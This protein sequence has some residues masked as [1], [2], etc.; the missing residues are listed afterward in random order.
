MSVPLRAVVFDMDGVLIDSH[1]AHKHAWRLLLESIGRQVSTDDLAFV[2]DGRTRSDMLRYFF[3]DLTDVQIQA[4]SA[5]KDAHFRSV[6]SNIDVVHGV[7]SF[8]SC[9]A[10]AAIPAAVA[11][12]ASRVRAIEML[13]RLHL[14]PCFQSVVTASDV[15]NGKPAPD[16]YLRAVDELGVEPA[17]AIAFEDAVSGVT[18][19]VRA[20]M[21]CVGIASGANSQLLWR[22]G[23]S[24]V[25]QDFRDLTIPELLAQLPER[26]LSLTSV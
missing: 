25:L 4:Y 24:L 5:I 2:T 22:A 1:P 19:A 20:G 6:S 21:T 7:R 18:A 12:S 26:P 23:A 11:T 13:E 14:A 3:G 10:S 17:N 16:V 15:A 8:L 9:L